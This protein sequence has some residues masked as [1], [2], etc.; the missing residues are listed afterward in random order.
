[1]PASPSLSEA[2]RL[3]LKVGCLGFGGPAGQIALMHRLVVEE[4]GWIGEAEFLHALNF[5]MLLPG[6]EAQQ[7]SV[8]L[9]WKLHGAKGGLIAGSLF[10]LP[11]LLMIWGLSA[12]YALYRTNDLLAGVFLGL[13]AAVLA[14]VAEALLRIARR[15]LKTRLHWFIAAAF[16]ALAVLGLP[17]P[18]IVLAA[19]LIGL[20]CKHAP[21]SAP[22]APPSPFGLARFARL[23]AGGLLLW[24]GPSAVLL[25]L[26]GSGSLFSQ[27][28]VFF[29]KM[30]VVTFGGAY[31]V[32]PYVAQQAVDYYRWLSPAE[33]I[34]GL[35]LA[36]TTPGPLI[37]VLSYV[38]FVAAFDHPS[39]LP[40]LLAG[41]L[42]LLTV[43]YVTFAPCF[44]W[45]FLVAPYV[46]RLRASLALSGA[47]SGIGAATVGII[48]YLTAWFALHVLFKR[49]TP[50]A[51]GP[52][53]L[54][55][56]D[57]PSWNAPALLLM[58]L[59]VI[60]LLRFHCGIAVLLGGAGLLG[61]GLQL[62]L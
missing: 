15:A 54:N 56:P 22:A 53:R 48:A 26:T 59:S 23:L 6:P 3:W 41:S 47:L 14:L 19:A 16:L 43:T 7:L 5:C 42:G 2:T 57:L 55:L 32:L 24:L 45:I 30:A 28:S 13:K 29:A 21:D 60:A 1:M 17:F 8:Y 10:V 12:L 25:I 27:L 39:G 31:A 51:L 37:L 49:F 46:E 9:G 36:E 52:L 61:L 44:L 20:S 33:M 58:A 35:A 40:P 50:V 18:L 62:W 34:D 11:G 38:G 4:K